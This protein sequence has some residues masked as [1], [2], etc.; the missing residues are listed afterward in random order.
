[1]QVNKNIWLFKWFRDQKKKIL[2]M[3]VKFFVA[4]IIFKVVAINNISHTYFITLD[5]KLHPNIHQIFH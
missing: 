2:D 1:M 5:S 4:L 3:F